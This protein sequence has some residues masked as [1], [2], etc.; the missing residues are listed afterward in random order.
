MLPSATRLQQEYGVARG[1]IRRALEVLVREGLIV[2]EPSYGARVREPSERTL[3]SVPRGARWFSRPASQDERAKHGLAEGAYV[4]V[5]MVGG[6]V[7]G[8]Y[9][10]DLTEFGSS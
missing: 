8:V 5:V 1:T 3:V 2:V 9:V 7:R 4:S 10:T 6:L